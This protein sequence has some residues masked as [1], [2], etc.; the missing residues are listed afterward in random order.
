[1]KDHAGV[2]LRELHLAHGEVASGEDPRGGS[3]HLR[4]GRAPG[5]RKESQLGVSVLD[6]ELDR[7]PNRRVGG[8]TKGRNL[9][10][11][12]CSEQ[13]HTALW[14]GVELFVTES[15]DD[16]EPSGSRASISPWM[17]LGV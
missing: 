4:A 16:A 15:V 5:R 7:G 12:L 13:N 10:L 11:Q 14:L 9:D 6:A 17:L 8:R 3:W 2:V 1:M